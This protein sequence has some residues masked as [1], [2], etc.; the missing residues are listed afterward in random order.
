MAAYAM[1]DSRRSQRQQEADVFRRATAAL[2]AARDCGLVATMRAIAD[3]RRLWLTVL[4]LVRDPDNALPV[5][6]RGDLA[7]IGTTVQRI[8]DNPA[9]DLEFLIAVNDHIAAGLAGEP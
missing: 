3:N 9:P 1:A 7:S 2:R 5:A 6:L 4:D 8:M